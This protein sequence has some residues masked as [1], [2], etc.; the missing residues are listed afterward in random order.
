MIICHLTVDHLLRV[1]LCQDLP[2]FQTPSLQSPELQDLESPKSNFSVQ[3]SV[4]PFS[5]DLLDQV[6][7]QSGD[8]PESC[9]FRHR[10]LISTETEKQVDDNLQCICRSFARRIQH[11]IYFL[12]MKLV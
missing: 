1:S 6:T 2:F 8:D 11:W 7:R 12:I 10:W 3:S 4:I 5:A 9:V